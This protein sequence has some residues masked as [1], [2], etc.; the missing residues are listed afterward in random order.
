ME[1]TTNDLFS[2]NQDIWLKWGIDIHN[3]PEQVKRQNSAASKDTTPISVS[4][5]SGVFHGSKKDY[6]T[7]LSTCSCRD[8]AIRK[9]PCKHMYRLAYEL[10]VY[11]I[12]GVVTD[13]S[14]CNKKRIDDVMSIV[15]SLPDEMQIMYREI[16]FSCG[17]DNKTSKG[18]MLD[19]DTAN[20]FIDKGLLC[21]VTDKTKL[22]SHCHV[23]DIRN[24]LKSLT[25][26]ELPKKGNELRKFALNNFPDSDYPLPSG[27]LCLELPT[28]I[29]HLAMS[30]RKRL[31]DKF[32]VEHY[33]YF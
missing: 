32:P 9:K 6:I 15:F 22:F 26:E 24:V 23:R 17:N 18:Y 30:I 28:D 19:I 12:D 20:I 8:F 29:A 3:D 27:K 13:N 5:Y 25:D 21:P 16:C 4:D 11:M 14:V 2:E 1:N 10:D 31:Y 33:S 7:S